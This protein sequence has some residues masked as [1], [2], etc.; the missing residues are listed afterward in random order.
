MTYI[1]L[2]VTAVRRNGRRSVEYIPCYF[3]FGAIVCFP[4]FLNDYISLYVLLLKVLV[5]YNISK[6][7]ALIAD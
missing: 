4:Y 7:T 6:P 3:W 1:Y 2:E 5:L